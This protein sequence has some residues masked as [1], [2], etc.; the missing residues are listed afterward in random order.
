M[1][2]LK[3]LFPFMAEPIFGALPRGLL[4]N[5]VVPAGHASLLERRRAELIIS[6]MRMVAGLF[7]LLTPL[8]IIVDVLVFSWP[9][10]IMLVIGRLV[11]SIAFGI[12]ARS[13]RKSA[14]M[15]DAYRALAFMF[16]IPTL[17][18]I[19]SHPLLSHFHM[20]GP[21]AAISAGYAFLPFVMVAGL[22]VFPLTA[23]ESALFALPVLAAEALVALMQLNLL[24]WSSHLGAFW[25]LLLIAAVAALAGMSQLSFM[26]SL[27]QQASHDA[28]TGC[29]SRASGEELLDI[30]FHISSRSGAPLAV[31]FVDLDDFKRIND[32]Y[33]HD[34]GDRALQS[35][36]EALRSNL[37]AGDILLRWGGEEFVIILP[38]AS[39]TTAATT[40]ARLRERGLG[41]RP[42]GSQMTA[43][44]GL[45]E[46]FADRA[47]N[48]R[49]LLEIADQRMYQAKVAGKNCCVGCTEQT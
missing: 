36:A 37:R 10:T 15:K 33:G 16:A 32:Q 46:R 27:V 17:F 9:V 19:Y 31:V 12:L 29:F 5:L 22:A 11:T 23:V 40:V 4:R 48:W 1:Q 38:G 2:T 25:L 34:S 49:K 21:A 8:W 45:A 7:A 28:L 13:Y 30:Q 42:D 39:G 41:V 35:A 43:S 6:R 14:R 26:I 20:I 18:F 24:S 3:L 47:D 44:F